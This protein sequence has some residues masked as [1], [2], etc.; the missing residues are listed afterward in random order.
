MEKENQEVQKEILWRKERSLNWLVLLYL[1][2]EQHK[3]ALEYIKKNCSE[4][5]YI[6]HQPEEN[7]KKEH[8]HVVLRFKNYRWNTA[9]A[10]EFMIEINMFQKLRNL[11][12]GLLYLVHYREEEK[13]QYSIDDVKG[14]LKSRLQ[15]LILSDGKDATDKANDIVEWIYS[16][17][18]RLTMSQLFKFASQ[19]GCY[20]DLVRGLSLFRDIMYE[21]N[22]SIWRF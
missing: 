10:E 11:D 1:E 4:Y 16:Q 6:L 2:N 14:T 9:L 8:V 12:S 13:I 18:E 22:D 15:R 21:H 19:N 3:N 20:G 5:A 17:N 7:E